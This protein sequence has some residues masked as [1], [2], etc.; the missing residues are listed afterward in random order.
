MFT[1]LGDLLGLLEDLAVVLAEG[2]G[3]LYGSSALA[4]KLRSCA[5]RGVLPA[6]AGA[7]SPFRG[8]NAFDVMIDEWQRLA[9]MRRAAS[10]HFRPETRVCVD[11]GFAPRLSRSAEHASQ[12][13]STNY[14]LHHGVSLIRGCAPTHSTPVVTASLLCTF[15]STRVSW[16]VHGLPQRRPRAHLRTSKTG[17]WHLNSPIAIARPLAQWGKNSANVTDNAAVSV[18]GTVSMV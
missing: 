5:P 11:G 3:Y 12:K 8:E 4:M 17:Y 2:S 13:R 18:H 16:S 1:G 10:R 15:S 7:Y 6:H 9:R 14:D